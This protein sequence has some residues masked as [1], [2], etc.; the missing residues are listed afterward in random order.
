VPALASSRAFLKHADV[1]PKPVQ[2]WL[3][4]SIR[5]LTTALEITKSTMMAALLLSGGAHAERDSS[6]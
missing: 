2:V 6:P 4:I 1:S 3:A 5:G